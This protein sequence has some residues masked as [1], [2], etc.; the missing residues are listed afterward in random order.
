[1]ELVNYKHCVVGANLHLQF[2]PAYR[3]DIFCDFAL[4]SV[5]RALF[6]D[7]AKNLGI[8]LVA[9]A[10][11]PEHVHL[12]VSGWKNYAIPY[13]VQRFKGRSSR[14]I[15]KCFWDRA[16]PKLWGRKFWSG[17]YFAETVG[18]VTSE[19]IKYYVERQQGKHW[20]NE[21]EV[22]MMQEEPEDA[23]QLKLTDYS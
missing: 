22:S 17:G 4:I 7:V 8:E 16:K 6:R 21:Y 12:F 14:V 10:F 15:R 5:C 1:M 3:R 23:F 11:G 9:C 18:R 13:L 20:K 2:T 19:S